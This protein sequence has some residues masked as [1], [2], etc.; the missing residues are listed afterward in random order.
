MLINVICFLRSTDQEVSLNVDIFAIINS[1]CEKLLRIRIYSRLTFDQH[2]SDLCNRAN[3]KR[4][5]S[6]YTLS[7]LAKMTP[8]N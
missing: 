3:S 1:E 5:T 4:I 6:I 8:I 7:E 2:I